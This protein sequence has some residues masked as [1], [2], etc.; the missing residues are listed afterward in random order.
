MKT[1]RSPSRLLSVFA[2]AALVA[3]G[4]GAPAQAAPLFGPGAHWVDTVTAGT[5]VFN[6]IL[7]VEIDLDGDLSGDTTINLP[8]PIIV[9][10]GAAAD[11]PDP[12]DPGHLNHIPI[13]LVSMELTASTPIGPVT[14]RAGDGIANLAP[15]GP[16]FSFGAIDERAD[17]PAL[18]DGFLDLFFELET[19]LGTFHN[20]DAIR[21]AGVIDRYPPI[22]SFGHVSVIPLLDEGGGATSVN[23]VGVSQQIVSPEPGALTLLGLGAL[24]LIVGGYRRRKRAA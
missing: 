10:R 21:I 7:V 15:D 23:I 22:L 4:I 8:N 16:L 17:D 6:S 19:V 20:E 14:L 2:L 12:L 11:T 24:G 1:R 18:A 3:F 13:E 9:E 5:D